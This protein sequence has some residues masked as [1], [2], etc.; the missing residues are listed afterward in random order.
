MIITKS[1]LRS[2]QESLKLAKIGYELMDRKRII[3]LQELNAIMEEVKQFRNKIDEV[4]QEVYALLEKANI[5]NGS[6]TTKKIAYEIPIDNSFKVVYRSIMG[7][8]VPRISYDEQ[9]RHMPKLISGNEDIDALY[10]KV[11][12]VKNY[13]VILSTLDNGMYRLAKAIEKSKK[14]ANALENVVIPDLEKKIKIIQDALEEKER[15]EFIR[16]K[17]VKTRKQNH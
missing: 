14:R 17:M 2:C 13:T 11:E 12:E 3:L 5:T 6:Y 1:Y 8:E 4:Y 15:E 7:I 10:V 9:S 16:M